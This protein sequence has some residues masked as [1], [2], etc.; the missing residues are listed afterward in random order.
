MVLGLG[1]CVIAVVEM[2]SMT[3]FTGSTSVIH[4]GVPRKRI[5]RKLIRSMEVWDGKE[6]QK[7]TT[8]DVSRGLDVK[9]VNYEY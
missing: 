6:S 1:G 2:K 7:R 5:S 9:V 4:N 3:K 8:R